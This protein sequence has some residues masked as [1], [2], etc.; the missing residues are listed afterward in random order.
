MIF[1]TKLNFQ[2]VFSLSLFVC[3][4]V[5]KIYFVVMMRKMINFNSLCL[6]MN[7]YVVFYKLLLKPKKL[8]N[9]YMIIYNFFTDLLSSY[10]LSYTAKDL[11]LIYD[12]KIW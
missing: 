6:K 12:G 1:N 8:S 4:K 7:T 10:I 3:M 9:A 5:F 11:G 2:N